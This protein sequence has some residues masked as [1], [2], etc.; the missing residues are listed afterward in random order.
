[1]FLYNYIK[2]Y[3]AFTSMIDIKGFREVDVHMYRKTVETLQGCH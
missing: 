3:H 2:E 1:M